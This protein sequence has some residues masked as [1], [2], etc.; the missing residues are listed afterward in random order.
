[1]APAGSRVP[2]P[3]P[4]SV[5]LLG[6]VSLL[7]DASSEMIF[8]LLPA[9]LAARIG[10]APLLLG[11]MEGVADLISAGFKALSGRWADRARRL[12]P[13]VIAGYAIAG[14]ARPLMAFVV[15]WWQPLLIRSL[16]RVGK[17]LR[18][19]PRDALIAGAVEAS[20]RGRAFG[21][22]RGMDHAGAALGALIAMGLVG[23]GVEVARVF[24]LAAI[25]A[26]LAV[27]ALLWVREPPREAIPPVG[28][29]PLR[30]LEPMPRRVWAYLAPVTLFALANSTDA[31]LLLK[32]SEQGVEPATLPFAWLVLHAVKAAVSYP[33][34]VIADRVGKGR[35]VAIGWTLYGLSYLGLAYSPSASFTFVVIVFYGLYHALSEGAER[36]LLADL[37][38]VE[39]RGRAFGAY[40]ALAGVGSLV[41]G[42]AF[43]GIWYRWGSS[44]AFLTAAGIALVST[45]T[46]GLLL[47]KARAQG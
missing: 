14:F 34:G 27:L 8:P 35:V 33:A 13:L 29:V 24:L 20:S 25:P 17:G 18:T 26:G 42:L 12:K 9:F 36:A 39:S 37:T 1:M 16:D 2:T 19:S 4:R 15:S 5:I 30:A 6:L 31:F 28:G 3:L 45:A 43:G 21:F 46:L 38:P 41:A 22:H 7:T 32:L 11:A 10:Q 44:A 40:A 23:L 47:P